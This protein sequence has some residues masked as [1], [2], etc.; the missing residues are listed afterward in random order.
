V[1]PELPFRA[2]KRPDEGYRAGMHPLSR[3]GLELRVIG[4]GV[5]TIGLATL[6][7]AVLWQH[8]ER[9]DLIEFAATA[10]LWAIWS[11]RAY[12]GWLRRAA[13]EARPLRSGTPVER[14]RDLFGR[15]LRQ[16]VALGVIVAV[17]TLVFLVATARLTQ[18]ARLSVGLFAG[19]AAGSGVAT[20]LAARW[21][22]SFEHDEQVVLVG[23]PR[24]RAPWERRPVALHTLYTVADPGLASRERE[25][26]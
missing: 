25:R 1:P 21:I 22:A 5:V 7:L 18:G 24:W 14:E 23:E 17:V 10:L 16:L 26:I 2:L 12:F 19:L 8:L 4:A 15:V 6:C 13:R 3:I 11:W 20:L 9:V